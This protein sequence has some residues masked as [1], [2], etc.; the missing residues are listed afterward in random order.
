MLELLLLANLVILVLIYLQLRKNIRE[1]DS[2]FAA[3]DLSLRR[4]FANIS[5]AKEENDSKRHDEIL[6]QLDK[7]ATNSGTT[8]RILNQVHNPKSIEEEYNLSEQGSKWLP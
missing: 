7:I 2:Y 3:I 4:F 8:A 6:R 5:N 1:T